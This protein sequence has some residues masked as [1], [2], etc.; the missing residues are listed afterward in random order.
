MQCHNYLLGGVGG[1]QLLV[2]GIQQV[3]DAGQEHRILC[4]RTDTAS[5]SSQQ[6][7]FAANSTRLRHAG[8]ATSWSLIA[9][10]G[11]ACC[12]NLECEQQA[13]QGKVHT[14]P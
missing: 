9:T 3:H 4:N 1:I 14:A 12:A 10:L 5:I 8:L 13:P 2:H 6:G 7:I 11:D